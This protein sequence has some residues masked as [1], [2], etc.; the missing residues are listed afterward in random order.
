M[1]LL[2]PFSSEWTTMQKI[3]ISEL[4]IKSRSKKEVYDLLWNEGGIYFPPIA[5][6]NHKYIS[7]VIVGDK[8]HL[9]WRDINV[10]R[11]PHLKGLTVEEVVKFW[12]EKA[13]ISD[14]PPDYEYQKQ[15]NRQWLCNVLNIL[16][17]DTFSDF[18]QQKLR[19]ESR[20]LWER[21]I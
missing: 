11:I 3:H 15:P 21:R 16:L 20:T 18:V 2:K 7:Q 14:Y 9:K 13:N 8:L 1:L 6:A 19:I 4:G 10:C 17:G 5:D 12:E